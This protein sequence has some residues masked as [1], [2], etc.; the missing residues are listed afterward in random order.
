MSLYNLFQ[1]KLAKFW[2]YLNDILNK[3]WN[4]FSVLLVG[5]SIV[6]VFRKDGELRLCVNYKDL[7]VIIIKNRSS[8]LFITKTLNSLCKIKRFIKLNLK[9]VYHQIRIKKNDEWKTAFRTRYILNSETLIPRS[10]ERSRARRT[11]LGQVESICSCSAQRRSRAFPSNN[12]V[13]E[14]FRALHGLLR[15]KCSINIF[16]L[17]KVRPIFKNVLD[18]SDQ[19]RLFTYI[20]QRSAH[21]SRVKIVWIDQFCCLIKISVNDLVVVM[22]PSLQLD[23][24]QQK[25]VRIL[26]KLQLNVKSIK[27]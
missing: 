6:F 11:G 2:R 9:N 14:L 5:A 27:F 22:F 17:W 4:K 12:S 3:D 15:S 7:N 8:L 24:E 20:H 18:Q 19:N 13:C 23:K 16:N 21:H 1:K 25:F 26:Q 10:S